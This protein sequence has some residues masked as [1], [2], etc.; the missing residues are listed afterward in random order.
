MEIEK[1]LHLTARLSLGGEITPIEAWQR[2]RH[3]PKF[4]SVSQEQLESLK[5]VLLGEVHCY[6]FGA[7]MDEE[8]FNLL[9]HQALE[10]V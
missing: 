3:H 9:L 1:F 10:G 4:P 7:V 5:T 8:Y 6:G 2:L